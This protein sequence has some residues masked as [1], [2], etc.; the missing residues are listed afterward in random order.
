MATDP[1]NDRTRIKHW[2][3]GPNVPAI[4]QTLDFPE[5]MCS[6]VTKYRLQD[7]E[8]Q[9]ILLQAPPIPKS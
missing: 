7:K 2:P 3:S 8:V 6:M 4:T 5:E 9:P 1:L